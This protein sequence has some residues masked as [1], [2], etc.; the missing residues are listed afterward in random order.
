MEATK[1]NTGGHLKLTGTEKN[2]NMRGIQ[3]SWGVCKIEG[4]K[5][6]GGLLQKGVIYEVPPSAKK[7]SHL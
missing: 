7:T 1:N 4:A 2:S 6:S 3:I 5:L